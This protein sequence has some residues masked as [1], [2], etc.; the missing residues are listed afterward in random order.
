[1]VAEFGF[2]RCVRVFC[3][4]K[5]VLFSCSYFGGVFLG[6]VG[7]GGGSVEGIVLFLSQKG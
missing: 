2:C 4:L 7:F 5:S 3:G 1:M 6:S